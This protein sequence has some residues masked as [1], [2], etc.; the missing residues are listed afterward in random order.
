ML[1]L[2]KNIASALLIGLVTGIIM[3]AEQTHVT[4]VLPWKSS[5]WF[6]SRMLGAC[7]ANLLIF[8][9]MSFGEGLDSTHSTACVVLC[10]RDTSKAAC[11]KNRTKHEVWQAQLDR[12]VFLWQSPP[13]HPLVLEMWGQQLYKAWN[14]QQASFW[15]LLKGH[16]VRECLKNGPLLGYPTLQ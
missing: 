14:L 4:S 10:K 11:S 8:D 16:L 2:W 9:H 1:Y 15:Y 7:Q 13:G 12:P 3:T 5:I 6:C